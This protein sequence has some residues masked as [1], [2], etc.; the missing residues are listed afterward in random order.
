MPDH[1]IAHRDIARLTR[2]Q[3]HPTMTACWI[4]LGPVKQG[5]PKVVTTNHSA[6]QDVYE[7]ILGRRPGG[8]LKPSCGVRLCVNPHHQRCRA[9]EEELA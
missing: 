6:R 9:T 5:S 8:K 3:R 7:R 2:F 1:V 4:W